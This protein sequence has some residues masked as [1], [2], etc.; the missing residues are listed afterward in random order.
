M[1]TKEGLDPVVDVAWKDKLG[2]LFKNSTV[3]PESKAFEKSSGK[4][5]TYELDSRRT[6]MVWKSWMRPQVVESVGWKA[7]CSVKKSPDG[8]HWRR[9][10]YSLGRRCAP[11]F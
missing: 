10:R 11:E 2:K 4:T 6:E 8:G 9:G 7:S 3:T 5:L 1:T